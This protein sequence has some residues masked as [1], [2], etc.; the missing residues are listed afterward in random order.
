MCGTN[1]LSRISRLSASFIKSK[2]GNEGISRLEREIY[3]PHHVHYALR[4]ESLGIGV[5][6]KKSPSVAI[7]RELLEG[8][9]ASTRNA[10]EFLGIFKVLS[11]SDSDL[12][13]TSRLLYPAGGD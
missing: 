13:V 7:M 12:V 8:Q 2:L 10:V 1:R 9:R 6:L 4:G 11:F 3:I 5:E